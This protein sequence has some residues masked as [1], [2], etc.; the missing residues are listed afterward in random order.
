M[1]FAGEEDGFAAIGVSGLPVAQPDLAWRVPHRRR[2]SAR[3]GVRHGSD[4]PSGSAG[5]P[6][7]SPSTPRRLPRWPGRAPRGELH[8]FEGDHFAPFTGESNAA[9]LE[10]QVD[11]LRRVLA[12]G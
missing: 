8:E 12:A 5:A 2:C 4:N 1:S 7:T 10:S 11:F 3:C 6:R 9:V